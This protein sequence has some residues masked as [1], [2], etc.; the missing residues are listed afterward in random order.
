MHNISNF[1]KLLP[2]PIVIALPENIP[3]LEHAH[4]DCLEWLAIYNN[5]PYR[6]YVFN[7]GPLLALSNKNISLLTDKTRS[8]VTAYEITGKCMLLKNQ[9]G[10]TDDDEWPQ[11]LLHRI[12]GLRK[13]ARNAKSQ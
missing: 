11:F 1:Q 13:S 6:T 5:I 12:T 3:K 9:H 4:R 7:K 2:S 8:S 10:C